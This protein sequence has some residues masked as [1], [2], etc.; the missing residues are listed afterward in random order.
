MGQPGRTGCP[1]NRMR[2]RQLWMDR[3]PNGVSG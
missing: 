2:L 1:R 3:L